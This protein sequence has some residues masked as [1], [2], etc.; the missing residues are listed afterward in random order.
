MFITSHKFL[1]FFL[2]IVCFV[3]G[4]IL[5]LSRPIEIAGEQEYG[6]T[7]SK[8]FAEKMGLDWKETYMA[9]LDDLKADK[10]RLS[11]YWDQS[12]PKESEYSFDDIIWQVSEAEK[13][14]ADVILAIG[15]K[16]PRWPECHIPEWASSLD[17]QKKQELVLKYI[18]EAVSRLKDFKNIKI[19]Q[20][21]NEPF[22]GFGECPVINKENLENEI[23]LVRSIDPSRP[24][25]VTDSGELGRWIPA[26]RR[27][28][29]FGTTMYFQIYNDWIGHFKYPIRPGFFRF[30]QR[31]TDLSAGKKPKMVIEFQMEPWNK[32]QNYETSLEDQFAVFSESDFDKRVEFVKKTGFDTVYLWGAE[33][34]YWL[35]EKHA[36][37]EFWEKAKNLFK[38]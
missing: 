1:F 30:K 15:R 10:L 36:K 22:L 25:L 31:L 38:K 33:W 2:I 7:F 29:I 13:G 14:G 9:I 24:I 5:Y 18:A 20:V 3:L 23:F 11:A 12:E 34:W 21:E 16:L 32:K 27:G 37:P 28:D 35:K 26:A 19:W 17:E 8:P 4:V 6:V